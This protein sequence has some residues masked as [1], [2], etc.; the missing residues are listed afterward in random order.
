MDIT[1]VSENSEFWAEII[2]SEPDRRRPPKS[3]WL[4]QF[5]FSAL[6]QGRRVVLHMVVSDKRGAGVLIP[7]VLLPERGFSYLSRNTEGGTNYP[8]G[9]HPSVVRSLCRPSESGFCPY[10]LPLEIRIYTQTLCGDSR[11]IT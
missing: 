3:A 4:Q 9:I 5:P 2:P 6:R 10:I 8:R 1:L 11:T 7:Y